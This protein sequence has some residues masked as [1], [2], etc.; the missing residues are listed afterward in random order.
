MASTTS[1]T[2][3]LAEVYGMEVVYYGNNNNGGAC[4]NGNRHPND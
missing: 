3:S 4:L 1:S 2:E